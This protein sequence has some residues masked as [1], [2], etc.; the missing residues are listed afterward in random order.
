MRASHF[1]AFFM[2]LFSVSIL[3][4]GCDTREEKVEIIPEVQGS[5]L[6]NGRVAPITPE[7]AAELKN[8]ISNMSLVKQYSEM[9]A[10]ISQQ[11]MDTLSQHM[12]LRGEFQVIPR[13]NHYEVSFP[14]RITILPQEGD[15]FDSIQFF[16]NIKL[17]V[18]PTGDP[19]AFY[20]EFDAEEKP[21]YAVLN[22]DGKSE[23]FLSFTYET[24]EP[25]KALWHNDFQMFAQMTGILRNATLNIQIPEYYRR[26]FDDLD[27]FKVRVQ[28]LR[29]D[30]MLEPDDDNIWSGRYN[31]NF[32]NVEITLPQGVGDVQI[33]KIS[34]EQNMEKLNPAVYRDFFD[35]YEDL[36][37]TLYNFEMTTDTENIDFLPLMKAYKSLLQDGFAGT[38]MEMKISNVSVT[39]NKTPENHLTEKKFGLDSASFSG[40]MKGAHENK[41]Q[42]GVSY[43]LKGID[44]GMKQFEDEFGGEAPQE[45]IPKNANFGFSVKNLPAIS[46][47]DKAIE[48]FEKANGDETV[49]ENMFLQAQNDFINILV[50]AD[51]KL[52]ID[53]TYIGND[54]WL[55][56]TNG[57]AKMNAEAMMKVQGET[58]VR[59]YGMDYLIQLMEQRMNNPDTAP[60]SRMMIQQ[61]MQGLGMMQ[62][63]GQ[64]KKDENGRDYRGYTMTLTP[65]GQMQMNGTDMN[66]LMGAM[67]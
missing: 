9:F 35:Q 63:F 12:E 65:E 18:R 22:K 38:D 16:H 11:D 57:M 64:Q 43:T 2:M 27:M 26:E 30:A 33:L 52:S 37:G 40:F 20:V 15:D 56:L 55:L 14:D 53:D 5:L 25:Y 29:S 23:E 8:M 4:A 3:L 13:T 31:A 67:P 47:M 66:Q 41:A 6:K 28:D 7:G 1:Y 48:I 54:I 45:I 21:V 50:D 17:R 32:D 19:S 58:E 51:T 46:L 24:S 60:A 62:L 61:A 49:M 36:I 59:F 42:F 10:Q 44:V 39:L 34:S